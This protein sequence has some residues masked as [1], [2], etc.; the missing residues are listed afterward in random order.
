MNAI[1]YDVLYVKSSQKI[2]KIL[3]IFVNF[4]NLMYLMC[5]FSKGIITREHPERVA[6]DAARLGQL[7]K[8]G[9]RPIS[10]TFIFS[11][12]DNC[13]TKYENANRNPS[14]R[15]ADRDT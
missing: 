3:I 2:V 13:E 1:Y 4:S 8:N 6:F 11:H 14:S 15:E 10:R 12:P 7:S 9:R 5:L